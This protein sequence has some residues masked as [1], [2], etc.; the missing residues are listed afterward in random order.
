MGVGCQGGKIRLGGG[1]QLLDVLVELEL[2]IFDGQQIVATAF[3]DDLASRFG[4]G[5]QRIQRDESALEVKG[6]KEVLGHGDLIGLGV[7]DRTAQVVLA[8]HADGGEHAVTAAVFGLFAI[9]GDQ[10]AWRGWAAQLLLNAQ[11]RR[12]QFPA[13][14]LLDQTPKSWLARSRVA[15][16]ALAN[17]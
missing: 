6:R 7:H 3:Q 8:R 2:V 9:Q 1:E 4:L 11:E 10:L 12:L 13:I 16:L 15:P 17:P 5:M 14:N